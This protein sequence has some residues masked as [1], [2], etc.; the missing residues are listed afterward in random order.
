MLSRLFRISHGTLSLPRV[1]LSLHPLGSEVAAL[2]RRGMPMLRVQGYPR[3]VSSATDLV[4][5]RTAPKGLA[6]A[7][8]ALGT[9]A[10]AGLGAPR[11]VWLAM[12]A[13]SVLLGLWAALGYFWFTAA[14][15]EVGPIATPSTADVEQRK[16]ARLLRTELLDIRNKVS[17]FE[18]DSTIPEGFS[19]PAYEWANFR[20]LLAQDSQLYDVVERAYTQ[21]HRVNEI[22]GWRRT[23][24]TSR[25]IGV[26]DADG[27]PQL[28]AAASAA[29]TALDAILAR[30]ETEGV[31]Q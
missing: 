23:V 21:A 11:W 12:L 19:F 15:P 8:L 3:L 10:A 14:P 31:S 18:K 22:F 29:V 4:A 7:A 25:L 27:L 5:G 9:A 6:S 30:P 2:C 17:N 1:T 13:L 26:N 24:S 20:L 28:D 16:A